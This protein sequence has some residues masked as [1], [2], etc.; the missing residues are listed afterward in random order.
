MISSTKALDIRRSTLRTLAEGAWCPR[1]LTL[2]TSLRFKIVILALNPFVC[3][4]VWVLLRFVAYCS[5]IVQR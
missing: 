5:Q 1:T 4:I 2:T 3:S